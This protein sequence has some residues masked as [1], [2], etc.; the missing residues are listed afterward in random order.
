M[1]LFLDE[2]IVELE[3]PDD[4]IFELGFTRDFSGTAGPCATHWNEYD[5]ARDN[6]D[7]RHPTRRHRR[8]R[9]R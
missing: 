6:G 7:L 8:D 1:A 2:L 4:G 5:F 3:E 9:T